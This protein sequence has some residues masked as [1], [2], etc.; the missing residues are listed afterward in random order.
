MHEN[1]YHFNARSAI[2][3]VAWGRGCTALS[4]RA[5]AGWLLGLMGLLFFGC[6]LGQQAPSSPPSGGALEPVVVSAS[7]LLQSASDT[8]PNSSVITREDI[9]NSQAT[10]VLSLLE[11]EVGVEV[12]QSGGLGAQ[13]SI[14]MRGFNSNQT[15]VLI[16]GV[17]INN[18]ESGGA[19]L[20]H[21]L[22]D[23]VD[24][25][26]IVRGN[27]SALYG[28]QAVG[29]VI[30][31]FTRS[32]SG[33]TGLTID[34]K[35]GG[36]RNR[37]LAASASGSWGE[38]G[39]RTRASL[40]VSTD[41][42]DGFSSI[43]AAIA[44]FANPNNNPYQSTSLAALLAQEIGASE[45]GLRLYGT[46]GRLSYDDPTDYTFI[47]PSYNGRIQI[48]EEH[49]DLA[50][51]V[52]YARAQPA[53]WW[54]TALQSGTTV[55]RSANTSSF[56]ESFDIGTTLS[57]NNDLSWNNTF[58]LNPQHRLTAGL[59]HLEED[60]VSTAYLSHFTR[61]VDSAMTGYLG[62]IGANQI[63][64]NLRYDHYSDFGSATSAL[65][66]WGYRFTDLFKVI[67]ELSSAFDAP[68]FDDL[69]YPGASN[70]ELQPEKS[71]S[72]ELGLAYQNAAEGV[73]A[74]I[75]RSQVHD[76]IEYD[77]VSNIPENI[78]QA[79]LSGLELSGHALWLGWQLHANVTLQRPIDVA[80]DQ[81]LLRRA[82]HNANFG[83]TR[84]MGAWRYSIDVHGAGARY[85]SDINTFA[86]LTVPGYS[87][88]DLVARYQISP[89]TTLS[90]SLM[91]AF[92]RHYELVDGYNT[93]GRVILLG[94]TWHT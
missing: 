34:A 41:G 80:T 29:G 75:F 32:G 91:N 71:R 59:E 94:V 35:A 82:T 46:H 60:G 72:A 26:E 43:N 24:H 21:V 79:R 70:P 19:S 42:A 86:R 56:P 10:D 16:D 78:D 54:S 45:I 5:R 81:V 69:Y 4:S 66:G 14:F 87:V 2:T 51:A 52:L 36:E 89:S 85:D 31:I 50:T 76:L 12:A 68:T 57:R 8:L 55:D 17:P 3:R 39:S 13:A 20:Q 83:V 53:D 40:N 48:N 37:D 33:P 84:I 11:R 74:T 63:Q 58:T 9:E 47:V 27:V 62:E 22:L 88:T 67:A 28:S 6:A 7:R 25:I 61:Q 73:R 65:L 30:Q 93:P 15:L 49:S 77:P 92:D 18:V 44:P 64:A 38:T 1:R 90:A 23:Q